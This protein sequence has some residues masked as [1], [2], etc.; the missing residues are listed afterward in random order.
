MQLPKPFYRARCRA[1]WSD[2]VR[3]VRTLEGF[4]KTEGDGA[5]DIE[6][7]LRRV[8]NAELRAHMKRHAA[9][10]ARH[11]E[12]FRRRAGE[13][14]SLA[15]AAPLSS[16]DPDKLYDLARGRPEV[17]V[18]SHGFFTAGVLDER[19]EVAYV[20][21]LHVA[22]RRA[23]QI[24]RVHR[25]LTRDDPETSEI[26]AEILRDEQFH[27]A[28]TGTWL[29]RWK[30]AGRGREVRAELSQ[31]RGSRFLGAW[32][33]L[34]SRAGANFGR[35]LLFVFYVTVLVPFGLVARFRR[36]PGGW[37]SPN[38]STSPRERARTQ[39]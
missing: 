26:F 33:R 25:D 23:A 29:R 6:T 32:K 17:E 28:Y 38:A 37:H 5:R 24:F 12:L 2:P 31:A 22:E 11:A 19:G 13:L 8:A 4:S 16:T 15:A 1:V 35:V 30:K 21:M 10:E 14:R 36:E 9:D 7:A 34:G 18:D 39:Y 27:V 3:K 20:A